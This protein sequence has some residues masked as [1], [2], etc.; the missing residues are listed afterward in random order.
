M[1]KPLKFREFEK[2]IADYDER[3]QWLTRRG[4]GSERMLVHPDVNGKK[5]S[6]P[7]TCHGGGTELR[8]GMLKAVIR[9]FDL[10][11]DIF[12]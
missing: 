7:V 6:Y 2:R 3:F 1:P 8:I 4:K 10:P 12:D 9:R 11:N 5:C